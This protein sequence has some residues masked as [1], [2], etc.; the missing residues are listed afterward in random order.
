MFSEAKIIRTIVDYYYCNNLKYDNNITRKKPLLSWISI[1]F[2][3]L[4][5]NFR[6]FHILNERW[7]WSLL[8]HNWRWIITWSRK[9]GRIQGFCGCISS[10]LNIFYFWASSI[11]ISTGC[12]SNRGNLFN[13][14]HWKLKKF[15]W[16]IESWR[17]WRCCRDW[18]IVQ[19][20]KY[21]D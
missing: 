4:D 9:F 1:H 10:V 21:Y 14:Y 6:I 3:V 20:F 15:A 5:I 11:I 8:C 7:Q 13:S 2:V 19:G 18:F 17:L 16:L 12:G